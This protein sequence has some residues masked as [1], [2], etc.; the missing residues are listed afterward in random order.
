MTDTPPSAPG[1]PSTEDTDARFAAR[2]GQHENPDPA[3]IPP[4][5]TGGSRHGMA[6]AAGYPLLAGRGAPQYG[7]EPLEPAPPLTPPHGG[8]AVPP[9]SGRA[10]QNP[11]TPGT[12]APSGPP[13][14]GPVPPVPPPGYPPMGDNPVPP[15]D[16]PAPPYSSFAPPQESYAPPGPATEQMPLPPQSGYVPAYVPAAD[17][18]VSVP[19]AL[20]YGWNRFRANPFSW[21]A[22][23]L[24]GFVAYLA[25]ALVVNVGNMT[26]VPALL[27]LFLVVSIV[28]WLLQAA[29]IRGALFETDGNPP[30]FQAFFGFTDAG[31]VLITALIVFVAT[32]VG[33]VLFVLPAIVIG[34]LCMFSLHFVIDHNADP[35]TAIR[36]SARL[37]LGNLGTVAVL[38][39]CV[40][41]MTVVAMIP[42]GLGLLVVGPVTIMAVTFAYRLLTGGRVV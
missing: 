42:C 21:I 29:M 41:A 26:S 1:G 37:V 9:P 36:S 4:P 5:S 31:N 27:L 3:P 17:G 30:D 39:L 20:G 16:V 32:V 14:A 23:T 10:P 13:Q 15:R 8:A 25:V 6:G 34:V 22:I 24:V 33:F 35:F 12:F 18:V 11:G 2:P 40:A 7:T 38:V 28:I 19:E